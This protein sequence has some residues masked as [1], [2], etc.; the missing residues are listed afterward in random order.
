MSGKHYP[1]FQTAAIHAGQ[2]PEKTTGAVITPICLS[3]TFA[4]PSPGQHS[5]FEYGR[6]GNPS[7]NAYEAQVAACENGKYAVAFSS[8]LAATNTLVSLL[9]SG[10]HLI[11]EEDAYGGTHRLFSRVLSNHN[12][13]STFVDFLNIASI[14]Q[15]IIPGKTKMLWM[16]TPTN[17]LLK[18]VD[19]PSVSAIA[20]KHGLILVVDGT[21]VSP[22]FMRSLDLGADVAM[23]SVSKY[24]NGHSD[25][26]GGILTT[27][28]AELHDKLRFLQN[29]LG[30]VPS[31]FDCYMASRGLKTLAVRMRQHEVNALACATMLEAH[32]KVRRVLY[33]G[34][35]SHPQHEIARKQLTGFGGMVT[36]YLKGGLDQARVFLENLKVFTLAESLGGIESL[37]EH[38][39]IMTHASIP[40]EH[41]EKIG[42]DDTLVRL[43]CGIEDTDDLIAD[44]KSALDAVKE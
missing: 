24:I 2:A 42:I 33:P 9:N 3:T 8:G 44:L 30:A 41:R 5:G 4:Q 36:I 15:A 10:D 26:I 27:S 18:V 1:H 34:L 23:H 11:C 21:F 31:P 28:N 37:A 22:Y 16:E 40:K 32:P 14:E 12:V 7:R 43:S 25:V 38:P 17:P 29:A 6:S 19:V 13:Q 39:A 35:A 20:K